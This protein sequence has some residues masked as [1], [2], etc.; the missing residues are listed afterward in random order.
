[1]WQIRTGFG[2]LGC[3]LRGGEGRREGRACRKTSSRRWVR[4]PARDTSLR[5]LR[6]IREPGCVPFD[7]YKTN[8]TVLQVFVLISCAHPRS[9]F[10]SVPALAVHISDTT[11]HP[12]FIFSPSLTHLP[13]PF[14]FPLPASPL[15]S[16][17]PAHCLALQGTTR[18][19]ATGGVC[20]LSPP[21]AINRSAPTS[22]N[23]GRSPGAASTARHSLDSPDVSMRGG[24]FRA[25]EACS[26]GDAAACSLGL[27]WSGKLGRKGGRGGSMVKAIV[28][29]DY[30][31]DIK[32]FIGFWGGSH[33]VGC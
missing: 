13:C 5:P 15:P 31:G 16:I 14:L 17:E 22:W 20:S 18:G 1:M 25:Q 3:P 23:N 29:A 33:H 21:P 24:E 6:S 26:M 9:Y 19:K 28:S 8:T 2:L 7:L 32:V 11:A 4:V 27:D 10:F 30:N 12:C